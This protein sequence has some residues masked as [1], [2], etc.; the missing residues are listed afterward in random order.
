MASLVA[1]LGAEKGTVSHVAEIVKQGEWDKV[2]LIAE[3]KVDGL[4]DNAEFILINP[5][6]FLSELIEEIKNKL[7]GKIADT[8]VA[9]NIISG[10]GKQHMAVLS[11]L[12]KLGVGIRLVALTKQGVK[13]V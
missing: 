10:S 8:E 11:A 7:D 6:N 5:N 3:S 9:L 2:F 13:E 1:C 4:S 12:L